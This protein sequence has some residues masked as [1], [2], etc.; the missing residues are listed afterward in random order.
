M[1]ECEI[2]IFQNSRIE[3]VS[4]FHVLFVPQARYG[5]LYWYT[6]S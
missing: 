2:L 6:F 1:Y 3:F 4:K 5:V